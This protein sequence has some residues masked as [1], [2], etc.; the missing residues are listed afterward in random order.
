V[1]VIVI[2]TTP[3]RS[4]ILSLNT[5]DLVNDAMSEG[6]IPTYWSD[7]N[8]AVLSKPIKDH[9]LKGHRII[10]MSNVSIDISEKLTARRL[11]VDLERRACLPPEVGGARPRRYVYLSP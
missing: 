10:T 6:K 1:I 5:D 8:L 9:T 4:K 7:C 3:S 11:T 2:V